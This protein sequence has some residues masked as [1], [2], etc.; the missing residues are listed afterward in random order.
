MSKKI[1][2]DKQGYINGTIIFK[3]ETILEFT[4]VKDIDLIPKIKYRY[5]YMSSQN[6]L[7]FR[8]DNAK[9]HKE[10]DTFPHHKHIKDIELESSEVD[11]FEVL[12]EI[13]QIIRE[14]QTKQQI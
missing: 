9:H 12:L 3:D 6:E 13:E 8:Y 7:I 14:N 4:E 10:L 2:N 1:Y 11:L 5:H